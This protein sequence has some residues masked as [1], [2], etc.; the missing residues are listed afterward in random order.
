MDEPLTTNHTIPDQPGLAGNINGGTGFLAAQGGDPNHPDG[1]ETGPDHNRQ[2]KI[3]AI[4][5]LSGFGRCSLTVSLPVISAMKVQCCPL[6]TSIFSNHTGFPSFCYED[7]TANMPPFIN[8]W[9]KLGLRFDGILTGFLGSAEQISIVVDFLRRFH[10]PETIVVVDPVMGDGGALY[11]TY[12]QALA[13]G[14]R[15]LVQEADIITPNL[16]EACHLTDTPWHDGKW[17][18]HELTDLAQK[19]TTMGPQKIV[20]SGI[21][22]GEFISNFMYSPDHD[23]CIARSHRV[24]TSRSGTGDLFASIIAADA[25]NGVDFA[26]SVK[27]ATRFIKRCILRSME[28]GLPPT[29]GV[30]FEELLTTLK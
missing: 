6:P 4:N 13:L 24:G 17:S 10:T 8:E 19:L 26:H 3:A 2:R 15:S 9:Q 29:D 18:M 11:P 28:M 5:D 14:M 12:T 7:F 16:T 20:I 27:K 30:A 1:P 21:P 22:Q 25:V 23:P